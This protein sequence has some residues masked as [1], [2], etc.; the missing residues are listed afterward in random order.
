MG[1]VSAYLDGVHLFDW[2]AAMAVP[3]LSGRLRS[4]GLAYDVPQLP[5]AADHVNHRLDRGRPSRDSAWYA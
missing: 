3:R 5:L 1:T 4:P 2:A